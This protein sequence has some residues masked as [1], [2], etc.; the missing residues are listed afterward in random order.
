MNN[1]RFKPSIARRYLIFIAGTIWMGVGSMLS[2]MAIKWQAGSEEPAAFYLIIGIIAG[3]IIH[4]FGF[5]RIVDKNIRRINSLDEK[6][7]LFA[8]MSWR[9]YLMVVIMMTLGITLRHSSFSRIYLSGIYLAMG[10]SLF[11]SSFRYFI[12]FKNIK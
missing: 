7:C 5:L 10:L 8:F 4:R 1:R 9:S 3:I 11:L 12:H 6:P 2:V